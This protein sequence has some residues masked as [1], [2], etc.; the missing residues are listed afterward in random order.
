MFVAQVLVL[1]Y[2]FL[3]EAR[4]FQF[5]FRDWVIFHLKNHSVLLI[6]FP[7]PFLL[8]ICINAVTS[9]YQGWANLYIKAR[10][11]FAMWDMK[12]RRLS[13]RCRSFTHPSTM[14]L[15]MALV[16]L[17]TISI[18]SWTLGAVVVLIRT[19]NLDLRRLLFIMLTAA[20][21]LMTL[22]AMTVAN[23]KA[24]GTYPK[25]YIFHDENF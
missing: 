19:G 8:W 1:G 21:P 12:A 13:I 20:S 22:S 5:L 24:H 10:F 18:T 9:M 3:A 4:I 15:M 2:M 17:N 16:R 6:P 23:S 7:I 14:W 25:I 11:W